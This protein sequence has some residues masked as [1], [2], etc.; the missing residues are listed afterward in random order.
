M[1]LVKSSSDFTIY[2]K[3]NG[4]YGVK[5]SAGKWVNGDEKVKILLGEGLIKVAAPKEKPAEP[6]KPAQKREVVKPETQKIAPAAPSVRRFAREIG[7]DIHQVDGSGPGGRISVED[8][9]AFAK[10]LNEGRSQTVV[11]GG[12]DWVSQ[13]LPPITDRAPMT[14]S[15]PRIVAPE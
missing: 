5:N 4:R 6:A 3:R 15:P 9:K 7:I 12:I 13:T 1:E 10:S 8:V 14:V 11:S 2:K